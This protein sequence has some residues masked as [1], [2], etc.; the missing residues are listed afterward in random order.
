MHAAALCGHPF[1]AQHKSQT[2]LHA[3]H[4]VGKAKCTYK[5]E[6]CGNVGVVQHHVGEVDDAL[7]VCC[8]STIGCGIIAARFVIDNEQIESGQVGL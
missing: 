2:L 3:L 8:F 6:A 1:V 7:C 4:D 5:A